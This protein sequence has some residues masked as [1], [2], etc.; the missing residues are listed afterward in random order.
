[1]N[2]R[3]FEITVPERKSKERIDA[4]LSREL[5]QISRSKIQQLIRD[6]RVT[7]NSRT[8][9]ANTA[10]RPN[11][12]IRITVP[13]PPPPD[14]LPEEIPLEIVFED[15]HLLVVNKPAGM[16]VHPACGHFTGTLVN[17]LLGHAGR[18]SREN[19]S[20]RPG[21][22]HRLDKDTSGLLVVAK[23]DAVHEALALQFSEKSAE[24]EYRAIV[25]GRPPRIT[26]TIETRLSRSVR[27]RRK[28]AV[29]STGKSAVTHYRLLE[30]FAFLSHLSVR[31]ETGRTHQ[32]RVHMAHLRHPVFGDPVYGG[33]TRPLAE[34]NRNDQTLANE[35]LALISRQ[36]LHAKT[37]GFVH[38][39]LKKKMLFDSELPDDFLNV[40]EKLKGG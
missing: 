40:L 4:F 9:K 15:D 22:V 28:I 30:P 27:D 20:D 36:A 12:V 25:W 38:P 11:D 17:A 1:M 21:I 39:V 10:V 29:A 8:V 34:L 7:V 16:V 14:V 24:R 18:L 2:E 19:G 33:R 32:I 37:L 6:S 5:A 31:L 23:N 3:L 26:G 35:L 13:K